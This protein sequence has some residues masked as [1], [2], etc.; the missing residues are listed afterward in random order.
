MKKIKAR[1]ICRFRKEA[2]GK[3]PYVYCTGVRLSDVLIEETDRQTDRHSLLTQLVIKFPKPEDWTFGI[4]NNTRREVT[5]KFGFYCSYPGRD[6]P[7]L[8]GSCKLLCHELA[9]ML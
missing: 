6:R 3:Q 4:A 9:A 8:T 2:F 5:Q 7:V 1:N